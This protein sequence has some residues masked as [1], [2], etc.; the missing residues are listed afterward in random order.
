MARIEQRDFLKNPLTKRELAKMSA[1]G[2]RWAQARVRELVKADAE[3]R[4]RAPLMNG[5]RFAGTVPDLN[6]N[7]PD[8]RDFFGMDQFHAWF[9]MIHPDKHKVSHNTFKRKLTYEAWVAC[10]QFVIESFVRHMKAAVMLGELS[11]GTADYVIGVL[12]AAAETPLEKRETLKT[13]DGVE[14]DPD[15][16]LG[17]D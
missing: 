8:F 12:K 4:K 9:K 11:E 10:E 7:P 16:D 13:P 14:Y 17:C 3:A 2:R 6:P 15:A 1:D 5:P